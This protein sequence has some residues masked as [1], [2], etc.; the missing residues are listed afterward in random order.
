M[1]NVYENA[2]LYVPESSIEK[3][4]ETECWC[5]FENILPYDFNGVEEIAA[6]FDST[7]PYEVFRISGEYVG[8]NTEGLTPGIYILRQGKT[9]KKITIT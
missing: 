8:N 1:D 9:V 5:N 3:Y 7:L 4:K 2:T 6:D